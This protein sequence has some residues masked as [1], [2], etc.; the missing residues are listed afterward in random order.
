MI[1]VV[2]ATGNLGGII[3]RIL[4]TLGQPVRILARMHS[5]Y[6]PLVDAGEDTDG[7]PTPF[8]LHRLRRFVKSFH[9]V[10]G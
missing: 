4:L 1:L 8:T 6:Q 2:G 5:N 9:F 10:A 7:Q 3:T